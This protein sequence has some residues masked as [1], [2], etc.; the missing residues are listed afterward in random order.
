MSFLSNPF[1]TASMA[2]A[3]LPRVASVHAPMLARPRVLTGPRSRAGGVGGVRAASSAA[4]V[5]S[6]EKKQL[7]AYIDEHG[8][9]IFGLP[10]KVREQIDGAAQALEEHGAQNA[11]MGGLPNAPMEVFDGE[12]RLL[13]TTLEIKG[14]A[15]TRLGLRGMVELGELYQH[16]N[17]GGAH[18]DTIATFSIPGLGAEGR[19]TVS[20]SFEEEG[21]AESASE[22][23]RFQVQYTESTLEP[24]ALAKV[25]EANMDL[26]LQ[27]FNPEGWLDVTYVDADCRI[28][29]DDK[30]RLFV[31]TRC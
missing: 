14:L 8:R 12:W 27:T 30:G 7:L 10:R 11:S 19:L 2:S 25:F 29:R 31:L 15:K 28:G 9:G 17:I 1:S 6:A 3:A 26:L 16:I 5:L 22:A 24:D 18:A 13:Y 21:H 20:A 4:S 23:R